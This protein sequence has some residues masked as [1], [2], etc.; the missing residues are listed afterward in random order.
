[1]NNI[2]FES[3][4][5]YLSGLSLTTFFIKAFSI[6]FALLLTV[7]GVVTYKQVQEMVRTVRNPR[8]PKIIFITFMQIIIG[9][10]LLLYAIMFV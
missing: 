6:V 5:V 3:L 8:N 2:T 1:M 9:M 4:M 10:C 7:Y